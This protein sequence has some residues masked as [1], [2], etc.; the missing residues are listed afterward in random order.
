MGYPDTNI[1]NQLLKSDRMLALDLFHQIMSSSSI[2]NKDNLF[3]QLHKLDE[4]YIQIAVNP[5]YS[6][7][8]IPSLLEKSFNESTIS[9][10][11]S[12]LKNYNNSNNQ[13]HINQLMNKY[14]NLIVKNVFKKVNSIFQRDKI[15]QLIIS[16]PDYHIPP[17]L[18]YQDDLGKIDIQDIVFNVVSLNI[19]NKLLDLN[20]YYI[21]KELEQYEQI[22]QDIIDIKE[23]GKKRILKLTGLFREMDEYSTSAYEEKEIKRFGYIEKELFEIENLKLFLS[24]NENDWKRVK[25]EFRAIKRNR[26]EAFHTILSQD[27]IKYYYSVLYG[28]EKYRFICNF[29]QRSIQY[30]IS[31][32]FYTLE[33]KEF[34]SFINSLSNKSELVSKWLKVIKR[35]TV[36]IPKHT[37]G[38]KDVNEYRFAIKDKETV[39][40][41]TNYKELFKDFKYYSK[42]KDLL[43]LNYESLDYAINK[44]QLK[45]PNINEINAFIF[46]L[47]NALESFGLNEIK[48]VIDNCNFNIIE[49][50]RKI[51]HIKLS[52]RLSNEQIDQLL[53]TITYFISNR[54]IAGLYFC[55]DLIPDNEAF[56]NL[57]FDGEDSSK[58]NLKLWIKLF[59]ATIKRASKYKFNN[60]L[61]RIKFNPIVKYPR[62]FVEVWEGMNENELL[63]D[64]FDE[65]PIFTSPQTIEC[66]FITHPCSQRDP[67]QIIDMVQLLIN[68]SKQLINNNGHIKEAKYREALSRAINYLFRVLIQSENVAFE[69]ISLTHQFINESGIVEVQHSTLFSVYYLAIKSRNLIKYISSVPQFKLYQFYYYKLPDTTYCF[70]QGLEQRI[71][72]FD[73][74]NY[75]DPKEFSFDFIFGKYS[76]FDAI[77]NKLINQFIYK[78]TRFFSDQ[79]K[80][81]FGGKELINH[82]LEFLLMIRRSD[83]FLQHLETIQIRFPSYFN[84][85]FQFSERCLDYALCGGDEIVLSAILNQT[86][87]LNNL[88]QSSLLIK[89]H[90]QI[91]NIVNICTIDTKNTITPDTLITSCLYNSIF[92]KREISFTNFIRH[93]T[94]CLPIQ[95]ISFK[96][97][98]SLLNTYPNHPDLQLSESIIDNIVNSNSI[99]FLKQLYDNKMIDENLLLY[100]K[101][102]LLNHKDYIYINWLK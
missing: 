65:I 33:N 29:V 24:N 16:N 32:Y 93:H 90:N 51:D 26:N 60:L 79:T 27:F 45:L 11:E 3:H 20:Y 102:K 46:P 96:L 17:T 62:I 37:I 25:K 41:I 8:I 13:P 1:L 5:P 52:K 70:E 2:S 95:Q 56:Q 14:K 34:Y 84:N 54:N 9:Q 40:L 47:K 97:Y 7:Q 4:E 94:K 61:N 75:L 58:S 38:S 57:A 88:L 85:H 74:R 69:K 101:N 30:S 71:E 55:L 6:I 23:L 91:R 66:S 92:S 59:I 64:I 53:E 81:N 83:L 63:P 12:L 15:L 50:E 44:V 49:L 22:I 87:K 86:D 82:T 28:R 18:S 39:D 89:Y 80:C 73:L 19:Q 31:H 78:E 43:F 98:Y 35:I 99:V 10:I 76:T 21:P 100:T 72:P 36:T 68:N 42:A 67:D 48:L 77:L